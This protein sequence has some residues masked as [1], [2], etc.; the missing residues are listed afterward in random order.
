LQSNHFN[1]KT[2]RFDTRWSL[3]HKSI[4]EKASQLS[5]FKS[6]SDF[7]FYTLQER[8]RQIIEDHKNILASEKD[9]EIFF[10]ALMNPPAPNKDLRRAKAKHD[11]FLKSGK[12]AA[13]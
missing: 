4:F 7:V 6:L 8:A 5:G 2:A 1:M 13:R 12:K 3:E 10:N 11:D 9:Q